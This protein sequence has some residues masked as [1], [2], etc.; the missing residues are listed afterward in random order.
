[1]N[2]YLKL[3][4]FKCRHGCD[5]AYN[6]RS[7]IIQHEKRAHGALGIRKEELKQA[8]LLVKHIGIK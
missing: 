3:R 1:M 6:D 5:Q 8:E 4:P 2:V 7:N